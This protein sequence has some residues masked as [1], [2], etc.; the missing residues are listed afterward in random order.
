MWVC[1]EGVRS[2]CAQPLETL[3]LSRHTYTH[4]HTNRY[5]HIHTHV[6]HFKGGKKGAL[7]YNAQHN[8]HTRTHIHIHILLR[9]ELLAE[10][11]RSQLE[12][13][14]MLGM[15][16]AQAAQLGGLKDQLAS[17]VCV[18]VVCVCV[19]FRSSYHVKLGENLP[20]VFTFIQFNARVCD[21]P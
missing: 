3:D 4:T 16:T 12:V 21:K 8:I 2:P 17:E 18:C 5:T 15:Q 13:K 11:A 14:R 19:Y 9:Q 10:L 7:P 20:S 6:V 1:R